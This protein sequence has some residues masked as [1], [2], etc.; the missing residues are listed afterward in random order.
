MDA[1]RQQ[2]RDRLEEIDV[3]YAIAR[4]FVGYVKSL[5]A[6]NFL[7]LMYPMMEASRRLADRKEA[8]LPDEFVALIS[9]FEDLLRL[10]TQRLE[11][12]H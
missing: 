3:L 4:G 7:A 5:A 12:R 10:Q 2:L 8:S 11:N 1:V 9:K 6:P